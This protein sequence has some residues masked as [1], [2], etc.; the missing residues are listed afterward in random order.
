ML[1]VSITDFEAGHGGRTLRQ[2]LTEAG[3]TAEP[4]PDLL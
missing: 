4:L 1:L 2:I 3:L